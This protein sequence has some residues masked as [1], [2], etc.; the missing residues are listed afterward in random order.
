M[1][2]STTGVIRVIRRL[3]TARPMLV[4][5][6]IPFLIVSQCCCQSLN[7]VSDQ[8]VP[9]TEAPKS[10]GDIGHPASVNRDASGD[11]DAC[12]DRV[13]AHN[14]SRDHHDTDDADCADAHD[15]GSRHCPDTQGCPC[16]TLGHGFVS[17]EPAPALSAPTAITPLLATVPPDGVVLPAPTCNIWLPATDLPP[18]RSALRLAPDTGRAPPSFS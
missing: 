14:P 15:A 8:V 18:P 7:I 17:A 9:L 2:F 5:L 4:A 12:C 3:S 11:H 6:L 13:G 16:S 1:R 10:S